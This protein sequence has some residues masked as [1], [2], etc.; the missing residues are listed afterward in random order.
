[1]MKMKE[2]DKRENKLKKMETDIRAVQTSYETLYDA[3]SERS[4]GGETRGM[5]HFLFFDILA[6]MFIGMA[7]FKNGII[8]GRG[9]K[10]TYWW[11]FIAGLGIGLPLSYLR[12]R[13][14]LLE[15]NFSDYLHIK[16]ELM[17]FYTISRTFRSIGVF[18]AIRVLY[19]SGWFQWLFNLMR[20]VGQMAFTN[21]LMQSV[22][23]GFIFYGIG[24]SYFGKLQRYE[25]YLVVAGVW[26]VELIWSH[27]WLSYFRFGPFKWLWRSLTYWK[28]QP[29]T[30][31]KKAGGVPAIT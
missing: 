26:I 25:T 30:S 18:G 12:I 2:D 19:K 17:D 14:D 24:L 8:T 11:L 29:F 6:F 3:N 1:M 21:Y 16:Y 23:C 9:K 15:Y 31:N 20:P 10:S 7:F 4:F 5:F 27:I 22:I 28:W 13:P